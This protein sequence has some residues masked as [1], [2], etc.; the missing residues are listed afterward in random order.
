MHITR[1]R[2]L[3]AAGLAGF[4]HEMLTAGPT[5]RPVF[6]LACTAMMGLP[7]FLPTKGDPA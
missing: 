7:S 1:A 3:F 4:V 2:I 5:E 6:L